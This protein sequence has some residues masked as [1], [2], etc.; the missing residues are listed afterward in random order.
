MDDLVVLRNLIRSTSVR[1]Q[2]PN[3]DD[4]FRRVAFE[5]R[6]E[7]IIARATSVMHVKPMVLTLEFLGIRPVSACAGAAESADGFTR[8]YSRLLRTVVRID[9]S[10]DDFILFHRAMK[11]IFP[12]IEGTV[13]RCS[14][15][16]NGVFWSYHPPG[17]VNLS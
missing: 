7:C 3:S 15:Q 2:S 10:S 14:V 11:T 5:S 8:W 16:P 12:I 17:G 6:F 13:C 9:V 1:D 4:I